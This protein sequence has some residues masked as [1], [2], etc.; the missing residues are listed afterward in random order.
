MTLTVAAKTCEFPVKVLASRDPS[1]GAPPPA[2]GTAEEP[3]RT[4]R[5]RKTAR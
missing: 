5:V 1:A 3:L 4:L 2:I